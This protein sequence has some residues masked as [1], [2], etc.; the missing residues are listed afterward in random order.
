MYVKHLI[1]SKFENP[2]NKMMLVNADRLH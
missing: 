1:T 2:T